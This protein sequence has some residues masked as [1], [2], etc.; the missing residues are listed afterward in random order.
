MKIIKLFIALTLILSFNSFSKAETTFKNTIESIDTSHVS[1]EIYKDVKSVVVSLASGLKT[2]SEHILT[3][4]GKHFFL[5]GIYCL[6]ISIFSMFLS[7]LLL[8]S[9]RE[10]GDYLISDG[11]NPFFIFHLVFL[12]TFFI[13]LYHGISMTFNPEYHVIEEIIENLK[14]L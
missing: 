10:K 5:N 12:T 11:G 3:I 8:Y 14:K 9:R 2:T 1:R 7:T 6:F 13:S 4:Y